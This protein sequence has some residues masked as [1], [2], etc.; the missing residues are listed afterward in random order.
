METPIFQLI[1]VNHKSYVNY[2]VPSSTVIVFFKNI[3]G[4]RAL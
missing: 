4:Q 3:P 1:D 2:R